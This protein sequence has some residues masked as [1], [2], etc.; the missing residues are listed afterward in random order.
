MATVALVVVSLPSTPLP[1]FAIVTPI[2]YFAALSVD[3]ATAI[4]LLANWR[5]SPVLRSS[6]VLALAFTSNALLLLGAMLLL[7][8][9]PAVPAVVEGPAQA[10]AWLFA[11][12]HASVAVGAFAYVAVRADDRIASRRYTL[13]AAA[14][15]IGAVIGGFVIAFDLS[16]RLAPLAGAGSLTGIVFT[17]VGPFAAGLLALAALLAFRIREPTEIDRAY[18]FSILFLCIELSIVLIGVHRYSAILLSGRLLVLAGAMLVLVAAQR[19]LIASRSRLLEVEWTLGRVEGE[20]AKRAGRIRAVWQIASYGE[21][22]AAEDFESILEIA[23][24]ALRPGKAFVGLLCH[25]DGGMLVID[26]TSSSAFDSSAPAAARSLFPGASFPAER[27]MANLLLGRV[28]ARAWDDFVLVA[29][30]ST[31]AEDLGFRSFIGSPIA[32]DRGSYFVTF[33]SPSPTADDPYGEDDLAYVDV[34]ASFFANRF[35]Q[36]HH[37][38]RIQFQVEHDALTGLVNRVQFRGAV[39]EAIR[40][41]EPFGL[42]FLDLDGF[43]FINE[44]SGYETGDELLVEVADSI[45]LVAGRATV[46]RMGA[47]EFGLVL[48]GADSPDELVARIER[49]SEIFQKPFRAGERV[50]APLLAITASVGAARFPADGDSPEDLMRRAKV[51]LEVAKSR[52]GS[53]GLIFD[54]PMESMAEEA[55]NRVAELA[56]AIAS[57]QLVLAYQPTFDLA[58]RAIVGAEALVRWDHP[59][60]GRLPPSEFIELAERNG[61]IGDL[62]TWV[63][64]RAARDLMS[65]SAFPPGFRVYIN[66]AAQLLHDIPFISIMQDALQSTPRLADR[67][68]IEVTETAAMQNVDFSMNTLD[69]FRSWGLTVA[70]DDFGTGYSSLSYLKHLTVDVVKIDRSFIMGLPGDERDC[71]ITQMLLHMT[72]RFG[73]ASLAEGIETEGQLEWLLEHGCKFGQ[74]YLIAKPEPFERLLERLGVARAA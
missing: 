42:C 15:T 34:V 64:G 35:R 21:E 48:H 24:V 71:A 12:W 51:A 57:D 4:V 53:T 11:F 70:I 52:G 13:I 17:G 16:G 5:T 2:A 9:L 49:Y 28:R 38:E 41:R 58:T 74:G 61:L 8:L 72:E 63:C 39:C 65:V 54:P 31:V 20:S 1:R 67:L 45:K 33:A 3:F 43:R 25:L 36:Q 30:A 55:R 46:A 23:A 60:R 6:F 44:R 37:D 10:G 56:E 27:T 50:G 22:S 69:L 59:V 66:V 14:M 68:G 47:D 29:N 7:R 18:A 73:Y 62:S 19:T 26:A 40:R 32:T